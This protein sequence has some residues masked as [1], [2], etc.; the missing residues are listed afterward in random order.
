MPNLNR[1]SL[2]GD[3][4]FVEVLRQMGCAVEYFDHAIEVRGGST[5]C[6][7]DIDMNAISDTVMTL[8]AIAPFAE[9]PT[10]IRNI[11]HIRHKETDRIHALATELNRLGVRV[12]EMA[13]SLTIFRRAN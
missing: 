10:H 3:T 8:A 12:E 9:T 7:V 1:D 6:G 11:G 13:D 2:Q 4:A 5:L